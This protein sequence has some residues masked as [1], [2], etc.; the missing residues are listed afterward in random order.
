MFEQF[1]TN[2]TVSRLPQELQELTTNYSYTIQSR[3]S[4]LNGIQLRINKND[5]FLTIRG[6]RRLCEIAVSIIRQN[7]IFKKL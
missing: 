4:Q 5:Q 7:V 1:K 6:I 3:T 2:D